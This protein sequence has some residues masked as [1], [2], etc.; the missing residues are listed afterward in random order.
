MFVCQLCNHYA[1]FS[2]DSV[3]RHIG[4]VHA[5]EADFRVQCGVNSCPIVLKNYHSL[6]RHLRKKHGLLLR[7]YSN[8]IGEEQGEM[9]HDQGTAED[10]D[11]SVL[12][13]TSEFEPDRLRTDEYACDEKRPDAMYILKLKEK[14]KLAQTTVDD[15]LGDTEEIAER[16]VSRLQQNLMGILSGEG[17]NAEDIPGFLQAFDNPAILKPLVVSTLNI[18]KTSIIG[19]IWD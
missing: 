1:S 10:C 8:D 4:A 14:Y 12:E 15:I 18:S 17:I 11:N 7:T 2:Y 16:V 3:L 6:R 9:C 19:R 5:H 13:D